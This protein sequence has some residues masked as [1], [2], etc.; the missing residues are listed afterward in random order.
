MRRTNVFHKLCIYFSGR[1][2]RCVDDLPDVIKNQREDTPYLIRLSVWVMLAFVVFLISWSA[3]I[4]I[5]EVVRA[6]GKTVY[7]LQRYSV[8][9]SQSGELSDMYVHEGQIVNIGDPLM[10]LEHNQQAL[11]GTSQNRTDQLFLVMSPIKGIISRI[12]VNSTAGRIQ[13]GQTLA[14]ITPLDDKLQIEAY[15]RPQ[16]IAFLRPG[17][18]ATVTFTAYDYTT[19]GGLKAFVDLIHTEMMT[20]QSGDNFYLVRLHAEKNYLG[21]IDKPLLILPGMTANI[22]IISGRKTL[23]SYVFK[24]IKQVQKEA[25]RER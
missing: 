17:Q 20:G 3:F 4:N 23:L 15:V 10:R 5:D 25:L 14:E 21:N 8:Q 2:S 6:Q 13:R 22:D 24:P 7:Q 19:Y 12:L 16:D 11:S 18:N 1:Q 9:A